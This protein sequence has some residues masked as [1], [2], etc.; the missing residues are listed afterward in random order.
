MHT[1]DYPGGY[2]FIKGMKGK[3][4]PLDVLLDAANLAVVFSKAKGQKHVDLYYTQVKYLRRAKDG[5]LGLVLPTQ[6]KNFPVTVDDTRL[7]RV[8]STGE[9]AHA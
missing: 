8:L 4:V 7:K 1:R 3:S 6:E 2:V 9:D 5:P